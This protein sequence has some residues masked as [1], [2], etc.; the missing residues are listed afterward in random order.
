MNK[1]I[2]LVEDKE[3]ILANIERKLVLAGFEACLSQDA[4]DVTSLLRQIILTKP[5]FT[6]INLSL[7]KYDLNDL[8]GSYRSE[9]ELFN[10]PVLGYNFESEHPLNN[11]CIALGFDHCFIK[12]E[13]E[14][15]LMVIKLA[16]IIRNKY[17]ML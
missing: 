14:I 6:L 12:S 1:R 11:K 15:D 10:I 5:H 4:H 8:I 13:P 3:L 9:R 2:F 16:N 17:G 7:N